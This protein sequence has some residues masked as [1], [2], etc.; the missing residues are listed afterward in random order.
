MKNPIT[1]YKTT[2]FGIILLVAA[3]IYTFAPYQWPDVDYTPNV[4]TKFGLYA[5]SAVLIMFEPNEA[6]KVLNALIER[7]TKK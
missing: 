2:F 3:L 7:W 6:K 5:A 4:W 1:H